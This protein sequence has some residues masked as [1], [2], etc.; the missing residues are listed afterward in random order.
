MQAALRCSAKPVQ[1]RRLKADSHRR[2]LFVE[3]EH[4]NDCF[5]ILLL[6]LRVEFAWQG[7]HEFLIAV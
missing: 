1:K 4:T 2:E 7:P 6:P 5:P 3:I